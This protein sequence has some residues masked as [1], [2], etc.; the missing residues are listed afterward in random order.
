[1]QVRIA[2]KQDEPE[3]RTFVESICKESGSTFSLESNDS[4]LKNVEASYFGKEGLFIVA[5]TDGKIVGVAGARKLTETELEL[6]RLMMSEQFAKD[7]VVSE[8]LGV[9]INFARRLFYNRIDIVSPIKEYDQL[10]DSKGFKKQKQS[11]CLS[12]SVA[13]DY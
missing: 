10:F 13:S 5:E 8:M 12:L 4:D 2:N 6:K 7:E 11:D 1:M 9:I 3:I